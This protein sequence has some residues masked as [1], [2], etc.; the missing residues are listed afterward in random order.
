MPKSKSN[1]I[2]QVPLKD[3]LLKRIEVTTCPIVA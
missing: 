1:K 3:E 2:V